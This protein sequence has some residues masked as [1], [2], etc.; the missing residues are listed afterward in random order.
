MK[1]YNRIDQIQ[2]EHTFVEKILPFFTLDLPKKVKEW[3]FAVPMEICML[4]MLITTVTATSFQEAVRILSLD[5]QKFA[6]QSPARYI[7]TYLPIIP[8][9]NKIR[10]TLKL[11]TPMQINARYRYI[12]YQM[13]RK[14]KKS[15]FFLNTHGKRGKKGVAVA[16][17]LTEKG[18]YG[19][20]DQYTTYTKGR[21]PAKLCHSYLT[22][23]IVCPGL[24]LIIDVEPIYQH[25]KPLDKLMKLMI[26][27]MRRRTGLK[28]NTIYLDRGFY[29]IEVLRYLK[30][31]F[32]G[33]SLM[34]VIRNSRIKTAIRQWHLENGYKAGTLQMQI[35]P[36][37][38]PQH[39]ILIF[40]P[41]S[42]EERARWRKKPKADPDA[43]HNDFLYFCLQEPPKDLQQHGF[44]FEE[45]FEILSHQYR[46]RW[47]IET[48]NRVFKN[49]W[50]M[51][52]SLSYNLR[53]WLMW[54]AVLIYNLWV[55]ENLQL[56]DEDNNLPAEYH[57]CEPATRELLNE[58]DEEDKLRE[59]KKYP[60]WCRVT[61]EM[62]K[63]KWIPKPVEALNALCDLLKRIA[64][65]VANRYFKLGYDPP[66]KNQINSPSS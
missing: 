12:T 32:T 3:E 57:C 14:L 51:T 49:V 21:S 55:M 46:Q 19:K 18:Y 42:K 25:G 15:K 13:V 31:H 38:N 29:Q 62:P 52:T 30:H 64:V 11:W 8:H 39:Y 5:L 1:V 36:E 23:Q 54:N 37:S 10:Q 44:S 33:K 22:F 48:G 28:I 63:R 45:I 2:L 7:K 35:G 4:V 43:I 53:Y 66:W 34:P 17:D 41:L 50:A 27:R 16:F 26:T 6:D 20:Q 58:I 40:A 60:T 56:L 47:S 24:R 9:P 65:R 59:S 61:P